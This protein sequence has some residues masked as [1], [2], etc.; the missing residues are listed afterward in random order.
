MEVIIIGFIVILNII[1]IWM[2]YQSIGNK[3]P[4]SN[5]V[6]ITLMGLII[7][8]VLLYVIYSISSAGKDQNIAVAARQLILFTILPINVICM[9]RPIAVQIRKLRDKDIKPEDFNKKII[10]YAV[11][12]L[13]ILI[14]EFVYI[15]DIQAGIASF[16]TKM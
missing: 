13:V 1:A 9:I 16:K 10:L 11:I 6:V 15:K 3:I 8:Y 2:L 4:T 12:S 7:M 14:I 5:K